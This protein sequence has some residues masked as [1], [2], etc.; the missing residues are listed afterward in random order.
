M[1]YRQAIN[2][3]AAL[4]SRK[5]YCSADIQKKLVN[6]DL[7]DEEADKALQWLIDE[8][9]IDNERYAAYY[10]R[11]KFRFNN[12]GKI[13]IRYQL[14]GKQISSNLIEDAL[15][16]INEAEYTEKLAELL[17]SKKQQIKNKDYWQTKAALA[18]FA[19]SRGFEP[20]IV[21]RAIDQ[22]LNDIT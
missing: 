1:D 21:F 17:H 8:K 9:F 14:R 15:E 7:S 22:L 3:A 5:E 4:C 16:Q 11:D 20:D 13:K 10:V 2:K 6:W 18:R 12:W 19:Q